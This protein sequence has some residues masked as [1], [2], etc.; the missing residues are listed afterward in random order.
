MELTP[1]RFYRLEFAKRAEWREEERRILE[2]L[3]DKHDNSKRREL[4]GE[5]EAAMDLVVAV[6]ATDDDIENFT[7]KLDTYDAATVEAL[8]ENEKA[9]ER[10]REN[11]GLMLDK[12][13]VLP[14]GR[15]V[16]KTEDGTRVFDESGQE[17]KDFD[18]S[19]VEDW[20]P[21]WERFAEELEQRDALSEERDQLHEYQNLLDETRERLDDEGLTKDEL[22]ELE[23]RLEDNAPEAVKRKVLNDHDAELERDNDS[24]PQPASF[25]PAAKLDMPTL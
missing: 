20:R 2:Q 23:K 14:D 22:D 24:E 4:D 10:V 18:P 21:R 9:L 25:R 7:V 13:Y 5:H 8:M 1:L 11:L 19:Q 16:F 17:L 15:R 12:A 6:L 3:K